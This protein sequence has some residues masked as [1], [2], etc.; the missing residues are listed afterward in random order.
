MARASK[1]APLVLLDGASMWFRSY[2][3]VPSSITAPDGRPVNAL[4]GFL[5]AVA[6]LTWEVVDGRVEQYEGG[7]AAYVLAKAERARVAAATEERRQNLLRKE[8]AWLRRGAPA[9]T[10]KPK[11][12]IEAANELIAD[13]PDPRDEVELVR[14]ATTRLGK[15]VIDLLDAS[16]EVGDRELIHKQT[17]RLAPGERTGI[18][19]VNGAGKSTLLRAIAGLQPLSSGKRKEGRTVQLAFLT[20]ELRELDEVPDGAT[21]IFMAA[22]GAP[23]GLFAIAD[24]VKT[25]TPEAVKRLAADG[26][27]VVM[28]TGDNKTT[29]QAVARRLGITD[30]E[31]EVLPEEKSAI[32]TRLRGEGRVVAM[33][34]DGVNDAPALANANVGIAMGAAGSDVA[35]ETADIALMADDLKALPFA[36]QVS[37]SSNRIIAQNLWASLGVVALLIPATILGLGIGPAVLIHEGSTLI[38]VAN[39]LR[40]LALRDRD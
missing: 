14:F 33:A 9:R 10:S 15:D 20:Q 5:D 6:T 1:E 29:A 39:A 22:D 24:P 19:G 34:G 40:L 28:L 35:L 12:R 23:A 8:L 13:V 16:I 36:V 3:G 31:A 2:F 21:V 27:R 11:F 17:W 37:Q 7:Y 38:V 4:R 25:T 32:V 26:V 18:V 30:V